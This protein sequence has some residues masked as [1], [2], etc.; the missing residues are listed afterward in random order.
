MS[1][2]FSRLRLKYHGD[3]RMLREILQMECRHKCS[4]K[5]SATLSE[6]PDFEFPSIALA[7]MS[8]SDDVADVHSSMVKAGDRILD[9]TAG[10]GID[11]LHFAK[12]GCDVTAIEIDKDAADALCNNI[13]SLKLGNIQVVH[14]DSVEWLKTTQEH[15]D[16]IFIDPA[17]RDSSGR[18]FLFSQCSPD[19]T[20]ILPCMFAR[21]DR[22]IVKASPMIDIK[23]AIGELGIANCNIVVIGNNKEC[24]EVVFDIDRNNAVYNTECVTIGRQCYTLSGKDTT[25]NLYVAPEPGKVLMQPYPAGMKGT[26]G[27]IAGYDKMHPFT[28][29]YISDEPISAF[30][31]LQYKIKDVLLFNKENIRRFRNYYPKVNVVTRN[32]PLSAPDLVKKLKVRE[33]GDITVFG[34]TVFDGSKVLIVTE[35]P[36]QLQ[37]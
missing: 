19:I 17:R 36:I 5:L 33:G 16:V 34:A 27:N 26:G 25:T 30:P 12:K 7:E 9:M 35:S 37:G 10:L 14:G 31:G 2:D 15:F 24:K 32:F 22:I 6:L 4:K 20:A 3:K 18:H 8:T 28:H 21:C 1:E 13:R 23:S 29:L 11:A